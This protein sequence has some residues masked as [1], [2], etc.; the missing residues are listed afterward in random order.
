MKFIPIAGTLVMSIF[1]H[2]VWAQKV[3]SLQKKKTIF[4]VTGNVSTE[5]GEVL[6]GAYVSVK[7]T[8]IGALSDPDGSFTLRLE[9]PGKYE[10]QCVLAGYAEETVVLDSGQTTLRIILTPERILSNEIVV[11]A[12]RTGEKLL[13]SPVTVEKM[14]LLHLKESPAASMFDAV[15]TLKGVDVQNS[16]LGWRTVN[17][18][19]FNGPANPRFLQR[20][21]GMDMQAPG[22]SAPAGLL[23]SPSDLDVE[24][25]EIIAGAQ[26]GLYG[27]N[28]FNGVMSIETKSPFRYPG[29]SV[30]LGTGMNHLDGKD[31]TMGMLGEA[32]IRYAR[33]FKD[34]FG[35]KANVAY[36]TGDDWHAS[37]RVDVADYSG[38]TNLQKYDKGPGNPGYDG[39]NLYGDEVSNVFDSV[40]TRSPFGSLIQEPL[41]ISRTGYPEKDLADYDT[42]FLKTDAAM[43]Y[44]INEN[45]EMVVGGRYTRGRAIFTAD[46][47]IAIRHFRIAHPRL[48]LK[49]GNYFFRAYSS[50]VSSGQSYDTR[51]AAININRA[52]KGDP[53]W[54]TQYLMVYSGQ[55]QTLNSVLGLGLNNEDLIPGSDVTAR[56]FADSDNSALAENEKLRGLFLAALGPEGAD[57]TMKLLRGQARFLPGSPEFNRAKERV[58]QSTDWNTNGARVVDYSNMY[59]AD[60]QYD[61]SKHWKVVEFL[62]GGT[63]RL[64]ALNSQGIL[65]SDEDGPI[66]IPEYGAYLQATKRFW[67]ERIRLSGSIR[68]DKAH[69]FEPVVSPRGAVVF[70][71][72]R[73]KKHNFRAGYQTGF[74]MP[75]LRHRYIDMYVGI[76]KFIGGFTEDFYNNGVVYNGSSGERI[77]NA[78]TF[79]SAK[80]F[81][82][83]G[84]P[85]DLVKQDMSEIRPEFVRSMEVGYKGAVLPNLVVDVSGYLNLYRDFIGMVTFVGPHVDDVGTAEMPLTPEKLAVRGRD[86]DTLYTQYRRYINAPDRITSG[87]LA[88]GL[89]YYATRWLY[90]MVG[91]SMNKLTRGLE[92]PDFLTEFNTPLHKVTLTV[93]GRNIKQRYGFAVNWRWSDG[94]DFQYSFASGYVPAFH[95]F[96]AQVSCRLPKYKSTV[97]VG[98]VNILNNRH[99][100]AFGGPMLGAMVYLRVTY[101][102]FLN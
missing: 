73:D 91:Y 16:A 1:T 8:V 89:N 20:L 32:A 77:V 87:G 48:E 61:F 13:E 69:R 21:D 23:T 11:S 42:Y 67:S 41:R 55:L 56:K 12:S 27:P 44:K 78:Y 102:D 36:F 10:I 68:V 52:W 98:G 31:R 100:E 63:A 9:R 17:T 35:F 59:N 72:D 24:S 66:L 26:S 7:G 94:Y 71:L 57:T 62:A 79:S 84:N 15:A 92:N 76:Y 3:D 37:S 82:A 75:D 39:L 6:P 18:R 46:N 58:V 54:F 85:S 40:T 34:R 25:I 2:A 101:D 33:V 90:L 47:R 30:M 65:F 60:F 4:F 99:I 70:S 50:L 97:K 95:L 22:L 49:G 81:W 51:L 14:D 45:V 86:A 88:A 74:R 29:L 28:A 80:K 5:E 64:F 38:T 83:S 43:H 96:D 93:A 19:G 53:E